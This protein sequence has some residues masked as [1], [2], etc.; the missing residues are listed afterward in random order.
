MPY[1]YDT[2]HHDK[3]MDLTFAKP[4]Q[5][6]EDEGL[7]GLVRGVEASDLEERFARALNKYRVPYEFQVEFYTPFTI[8][9]KDKVVDF[10]LRGNQ[11]VDIYGFVGHHLNI[12]QEGY[13]RI[14]E[15][16]LNEVFS[17]ARYKPLIVVED[18]DV[19]DTQ[20]KTNAFVRRL[21]VNF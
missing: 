13:D 19:G 9:S 12:G 14:R 8:P 20:E 17:K 21:V 7:T 15:Q 1:K 18:T 5:Q 10:V 16:Q 11:P 3:K 4:E 2:R 6:K